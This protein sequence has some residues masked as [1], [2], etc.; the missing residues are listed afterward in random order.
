MN[1]PFCGTVINQGYTACAG[2]GAMKVTQMGCLSQVMIFACIFAVSFLITRSNP[3][4]DFLSAF[5]ITGIP[6][7]VAGRIF[8]VRKVWVRKIP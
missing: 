1:C 8:L 6:L 3:R 7:A 5:F 2:C 4:V